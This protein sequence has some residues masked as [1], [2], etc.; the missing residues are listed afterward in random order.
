[1]KQPRTVFLSLN[2]TRDLMDLSRHFLRQTDDRSDVD[3]DDRVDVV[4]LQK[5]AQRA[6][7][8]LRRRRGDE[9]DWVGKSGG[10]QAGTLEEPIFTSSRRG[11]T[12]R[13][14]ASQASAARMAGPP[15]LV[16]MATLRP[17]GSG[18]CDSR[19]ATSKSCSSVSM[20]MTPAWRNRASVAT[21]RLARA[22]V[23]EV[24][25]RE[26][27]AAPPALQR[28]DRLRHRDPA[29]KSRELARVPERLEVQQDDVG[30]RVLLPVLDEVVAR[31]RPPCCRR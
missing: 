27:A 11:G 25:A 1:M 14:Y 2:S 4:L 12:R 3:D 15:E 18:W 10:R 29:G 7:V 21:S 30:R 31:R 26:P 23:C 5:N 13:P 17:C 6:G 20:R 9:V 28:Q 22:P 19:F 8:V 24:A 16:T